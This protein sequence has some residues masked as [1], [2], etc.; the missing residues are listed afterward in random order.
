MQWFPSYWEQNQCILGSQ[1]DCNL[2]PIDIS[3]YFRSTFHTLQQKKHKNGG[4]IL[5]YDIIG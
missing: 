4:I 2:F 1:S 5:T 3:M